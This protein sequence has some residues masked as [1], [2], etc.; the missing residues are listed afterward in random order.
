MKPIEL[1]N[2]PI[3]V[4]AWLASPHVEMMSLAEQGAYFRLLCYCWKMHGLPD[5]DEQLATLS[6][7]REDWKKGSGIKLR[8][9]FKK[10]RGKLT[11]ERLDIERKR[12]LD[13]AQKS[14]AGG[15]TSANLRKEQALQ[16]KPPVKGG[17]NRVATKPQPKV[18]GGSSKAGSSNHNH[19]HSYG[20]N[21]NKSKQLLLP[22]YK[23]GPKGELVWFGL[24]G[25]KIEISKELI[26]RDAHLMAV[27]VERFRPL[28]GTR[29]VLGDI[30]AYAV[31]EAH[32]SGDAGVFDELAQMARQTV[33][34][35]NVKNPVGAFVNYSK[36][37][38]GYVPRGKEKA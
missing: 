28:N 9:C 4:N 36:R 33:A 20:L 6:G 7:L 3:N 11:S 32:R 16:Q 30:A 19:N 12:V 27:L 18:K 8:K 23:R 10:C 14:R 38:L 34:R 35:E 21:H 15:L 24:E 17:S 29:V 26:A 22:E 37:R 31:A 1:Y 13:H 25:K 2:M 5:D